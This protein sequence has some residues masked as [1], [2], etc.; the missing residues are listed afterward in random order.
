MYLYKREITPVSPKLKQN[1]SKK[2]ASNRTVGDR[3]GTT[4]LTRAKSIE[5]EAENIEKEQE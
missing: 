4:L 1:I 3:K 2:K 5:T